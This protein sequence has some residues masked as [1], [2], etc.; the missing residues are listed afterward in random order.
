[1][2]PDGSPAAEAKVTSAYG[3][4][5]LE[6]AGRWE[7]TIA[8]QLRPADGKVRFFA[9]VPNEYLA[10][11]STATLGTDLSPQITIQ[12]RPLPSTIMRGVVKSGNG[13]SVEGASVSVTGYPEKAVTDSMGNFSLPAHAADGQMVQVRAEKGMQKAESTT[14]AGSTVELVLR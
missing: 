10:G 12:L 3:E 4:A 14:P 9:Q 2:R 11:D 8:D 6:G 1:M 7:A 5:P 13:K